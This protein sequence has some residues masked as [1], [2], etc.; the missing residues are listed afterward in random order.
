VREINTLDK[1]DHEEAIKI[2]L[3]YVETAKLPIDILEQ[4]EFIC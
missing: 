2:L 4:P 1:K 3:N